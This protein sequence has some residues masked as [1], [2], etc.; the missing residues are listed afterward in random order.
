LE[1]FLF[2]SGTE[3][4]EVA[5]DYALQLDEGVKACQDVVKKGLTKLVPISPNLEI[6]YCDL[7]NI[8]QCEVTEE[9]KDV[10]TILFCFCQLA[11]V[12]FRSFGKG[13]FAF[14]ESDWQTG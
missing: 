1:G 4:Q 2:C 7:L 5:F 8:S 12:N 9:N 13:H 11:W 6:K 3:K 14:V 10:K